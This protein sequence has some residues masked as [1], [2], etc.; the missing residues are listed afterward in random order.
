MK[1]PIPQGFRR[2]LKGEK[3]HKNKNQ[4]SP[5][6]EEK[7]AEKKPQNRTIKNQNGKAQKLPCEAEQKE[8]KKKPPTAKGG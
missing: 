1:S 5:K 6:K 3:K 2:I 7:T 4:K 8:K